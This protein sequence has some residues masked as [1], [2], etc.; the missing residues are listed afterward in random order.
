MNFRNYP[1]QHSAISGVTGPQIGTVRMLPQFESPGVADVLKS[2]AVGVIS[3]NPAMGI[4]SLAVVDQIGYRHRLEGVSKAVDRLARL[5]A[6]PAL[7]PG[8]G[9]LVI[10]ILDNGSYVVET[11]DG[12]EIGSVE[13]VDGKLRLTAA[14]G[15]LAVFG[16]QGV[17]QYTGPQPNGFQTLIDG[18]ETYG[19]SQAI[20]FG[21]TAW[22]QGAYRGVL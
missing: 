18:V 13:Y 12:Q 16:E 1:V 17:E 3:S 21:A 20:E 7:N 4:L 14:N 15:T 9:E 6:D 5:E 8:G 11:A 10:H 19:L 22:S 2:F